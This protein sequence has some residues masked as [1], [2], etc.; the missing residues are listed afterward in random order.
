MMKFSL[1][2][3]VLC[4]LVCQTLVHAEEEEGAPPNEAGA[5]GGKGENG[6]SQD[7]TTAAPEP[8]GEGDGAGGEGKAG[9]AAGASGVE[10]KTPVEGSGTE[11]GNGGGAAPASAPAP[12]A[13]AGTGQKKR[14]CA[15]QP[16][17]GN[18]RGPMKKY[19]YN[20]QNNTCTHHAV[21]GCHSTGGFLVCA[22]CAATCGGTGDGPKRSAHEICSVKG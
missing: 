1:K 18:C 8:A 10:A 19:F 3:F 20:P 4:F 22:V 6:S 5:E 21:G 15:A 12:T 16:P 2:C 14:K 9:N 11:G 17:K 7:T 13:T